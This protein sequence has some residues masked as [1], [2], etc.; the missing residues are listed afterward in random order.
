MAEREEGEETNKET[1]KGRERE[2]ERERE[3]QFNAVTCTDVVI[4]LAVT[5]S[6]FS[7]DTEASIYIENECRNKMGLQTCILLISNKEI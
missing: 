1:K 6:K 2:R 3:G 7:M 4:H 5:K